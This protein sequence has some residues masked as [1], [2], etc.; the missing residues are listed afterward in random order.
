VALHKAYL[1]QNNESITLIS[2]SLILCRTVF[3]SDMALVKKTT[4]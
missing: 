2:G 1:K 3:C 4:G